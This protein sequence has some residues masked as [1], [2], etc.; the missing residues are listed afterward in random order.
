MTEE[1]KDEEEE[2]SLKKAVKFSLGGFTDVIFFQFFTFLIFTFY[3]SVA[4]LQAG[5]ISLGFIIWSIWNAINDPLLGAISDRSG[6]KWGR[7]KPFII[8]GIIPLIVINILLWTPPLEPKS[9]TFIYFL[10]II[11]VW[12]LFYTMYSLN[13]TSLFPEMFRDIDQRTK[14]NTSIQFFQ[15]ISLL[16]AFI[17]PS[18]FIPQYDS[19]L[20]YMEY[21][22]TAI[23]IS[24]ICAV[25]GFLFIRFG[26]KERIEFS[27][28]HERAPSFFKALKYSFRNKS[29]RLFLIGNFAIWFGFNMIPTLMPLYGDICLNV[30][31]S[32]LLSLILGTGFVAAAIFMFLWRIF[33]H[34]LGAKNSFILS[35]I[36]FII[37]LLPL[38]FIADAILGFVFFFILGIG[39]AGVMIV[40][41]VTIA[42][43]I[44][45]DELTTGT[46][47]EGSFYGVNGFIVKLSNVAVFISIAIVFIGTNWDIFDITTITGANEFGL[48]SLMVFF[49]MGFM[50][51]GILAMSYFPINKEKYDQITEDARKLHIV[52]KESVLAK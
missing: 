36:V 35:L 19:D 16:I 4:K 10:I 42:A 31:D 44:D 15:V 37:A 30:A 43:I 51:I 25:G 6:L 33:V 41:D 23:T 5:L 52:K 38:L 49:P 45:E 13:Q 34:R 7:R 21:I 50:I 40:R 12:E 29:F 24:I 20:Y 47:R 2:Y 48:R 22:Y 9:L 17:L 32:F 26:F 28:D 11:I 3:F 39:L 46:R 18:L 1:G 8:L 27:K 14:A